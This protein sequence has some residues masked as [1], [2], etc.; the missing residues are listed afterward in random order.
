MRKVMCLVMCLSL[1]AGLA[2]AREA[3]LNRVDL[4]VVPGARVEADCVVGNNDF[5]NILGYYGSWWLGY[6]DYAFHINRLHQAPCGCI[7]GWAIRS[8][9]ML[10]ALDV[11]CNI[12]VQPAVYTAVEVSTG[13]Y[14]PGVEMYAGPTYQITGIPE[15][16][17][18]DIELPIGEDAF[19]Q[20]PATGNYFIVFRFLDDGPGMFGIPVSANPLTCKNYNDWGSGWADLVVDYG[21]QGNLLMWADV[22]CCIEGVKTEDSSWGSIKQ[23]FR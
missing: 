22:D 17:Y 23:L 9:H 7:E 13:C 2:V 14:A 10:L 19:C 12:L 11:D 20:V 1:V 15:L 8:V 18:W 21:F 4:D 3:I 6:E 16:N 5:A